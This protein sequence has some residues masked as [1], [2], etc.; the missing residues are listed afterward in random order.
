MLM[1]A[2]AV[3]D[4]ETDGE[5]ALPSVA[6]M[7]GHLLLPR[8]QVRMFR[9]LIDLALRSDRENMQCSHPYHREAPATSHL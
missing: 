4:H 6:Y 2:R 5:G 1:Y 7:K 3:D 9:N 8:T